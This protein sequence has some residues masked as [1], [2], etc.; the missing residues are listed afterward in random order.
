MR[1][2]MLLE[3]ADPLVALCF[4][5]CMVVMTGIAECDQV[6]R[7]M[8][9]FAEI[10]VVKMQSDVRTSL[11]ANNTSQSIT[12]FHGLDELLTPFYTVTFIRD[13][14]LPVM[15][16]RSPRRQDD[17]PPPHLT[18]APAGD[19]A[20]S[21]S[22]VDNPRRASVDHGD[23]RSGF[24][25][26]DVEAMKL[27][28][29]NSVLYQRLSN[30]LTHPGGTCSTSRGH[31]NFSEVLRREPLAQVRQPHLAFRGVRMLSTRPVG[32]HV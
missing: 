3:V 17:A 14:A 7:V 22:I 20:C 6:A 24:P 19:A 8:I 13:S 29:V 15:M 11:A 12:P 21:H 27:H 10:D 18:D 1:G 31:P 23:V 2:A 32:S 5:V 30:T 9:R 16:V 26:N 28:R 4:V 25:L